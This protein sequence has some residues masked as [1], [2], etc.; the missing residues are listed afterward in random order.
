MATALKKLQ[1]PG[2]IS[3]VHPTVVGVVAS[4]VLT[5]LVIVGSRNLE[6]FDSALF[7]YTVASVVAFGAIFF[8]YAIWLQRPATRAY[9]RRGLQLFFQRKKF[10]ANAASAAATVGTNLIEQRFIAKRGF[11]RWLTHALIMW[12]CV[13]AAAIT[14]PLVFGWVHFQLEGDLGYRAYLFGFPLSLMQ[15]REIF[16]WIVFHGLDFSALMVIAGCAIAIQRRL[17]DRGAIAYQSFLLDFV[18]HLMLIAISVSGLML[19]AS[20]LWFAGYMYSFIAMVHQATVIM[21]LFYLPFGKLFHVV[22]RPA[23]IGVELYQR[24]SKEMPQ[25]VCPRCRTQF[26]GQ[27]WIDDLKKVVDDLG[28]DYRLE[29]GQTVQDYCPRCKRIMR[30]LAY[31]N[32]PDTKEKVF[33]GS[34]GSEAEESAAKKN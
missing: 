27:M 7:G 34:R 3:Y 11:L 16:A 5:L 8:R 17:K 29:N 21:T 6:N 15:G 4:A 20:S 2:A 28:F 10:A 13:I 26:A 31:A 19:T 33:I 30:G 32:L 9:F 25:A 14:F 23:S 1:P 18:P 12:G 24:R 22:Q